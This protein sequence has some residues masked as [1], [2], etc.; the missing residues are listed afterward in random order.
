MLSKLVNLETF[1]SFK[2]Q[3]LLTRKIVFTNGCFDLI[4]PGHVD[5]LTK[6]KGMGETLVIGLNSDRSVKEIK[7]L[8]R[9]I[10][11]QGDRA[12]VLSSIQWVDY[13]ILFDQP[14]PL[15]LIEAIEPDVLVKGGD[16]PIETIVGSNLVKKR[17]GR[18]LSLPYLDQYSTTGI[19]DKILKMTNPGD[20]DYDPL[21]VDPKSKK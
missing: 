2:A 14:T 8:N 16:W 18:V 6:A 20:T 9:P 13:I 4:H 19:I 7:G 10:N 11:L 5:L 15:T 3:E 1:L 21:S 12:N 17:G